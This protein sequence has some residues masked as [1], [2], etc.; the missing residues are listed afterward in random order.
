MKKIYKGYE[1]DVF[2]DRAM[3][4]WNSIYYSVYRESDGLEVIADFVADSDDTVRTI[5]GCMIE[6]V[7]EF[8]KTKGAS[9]LLKDL[10]E[11]N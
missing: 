8:I 2:K 3:G 9:E 6:R 5:M 11:E 4:G 10:Y 7:D 1:I